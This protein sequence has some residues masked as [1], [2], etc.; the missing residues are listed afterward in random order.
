M[1]VPRLSIPRTPRLY[2]LHN[3]ELKNINAGARCCY[4]TSYIAA[5]SVKINSRIGCCA[6]PLLCKQNGQATDAKRQSQ[7]ACSWFFNAYV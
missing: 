3:T 5:K 7:G 4:G 1:S 2:C 6:I